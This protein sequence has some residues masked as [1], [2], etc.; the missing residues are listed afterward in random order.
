[1]TFNYL[2]IILLTLPN[3]MSFISLDDTYLP[4]QACNVIIPN[5]RGGVNLKLSMEPL[6]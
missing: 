5:I 6:G 2:L 1:M 3:Y 4:G